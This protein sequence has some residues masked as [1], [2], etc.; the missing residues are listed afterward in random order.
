MTDWQISSSCESGACV[1]VAETPDEILVGSTWRK[2]RT[3]DSGACVEVRDSGDEV[4]FKPAD[5][6]VDVLAV[7]RPAFAALI[8]D[9]K[10]GLLD[11]YAD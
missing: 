4:E 5:D 1:M 11:D 10:A 2:S 3:C 8:A 7:S 6:G 9:I